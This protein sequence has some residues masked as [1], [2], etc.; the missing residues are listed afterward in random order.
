YTFPKKIAG[1]HILNVKALS[2]H[3]VL[4]IIIAGICVFGVHLGYVAV[5]YLV[6][7]KMGMWSPLEVRDVT[8][9]SSLFPA[10]SSFAVGVNASVSEELLYRVLC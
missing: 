6:G 7:T 9:M 5:Y 1:E 8:T 4:E 10:F 3:T 2:N